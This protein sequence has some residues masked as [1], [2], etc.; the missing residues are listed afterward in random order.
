M[1]KEEAINQIEDIK[2]QIQSSLDE[3]EVDKD[4]KEAEES[5]SKAV[6]A[7]DIAISA[8]KGGWIPIG[9]RLPKE[10]QEVLC[11]L[12]DGSCAVLYT[13]DNWGQIDWVDGMMGT[14]TYDVEAWM[15]LPEPYKGGE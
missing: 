11:Q 12:T 15:E 13:Q 7:L 10:E 6:E 14:G 2:F 3:V 5:N 1:T 4:C 9:E 8:L